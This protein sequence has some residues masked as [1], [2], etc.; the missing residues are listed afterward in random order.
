MNTISNW[1]K[2]NYFKT[3]LKSNIDFGNTSDKFVDLERLLEKNQESEST[4][5]HF[6]NPAVN[7]QQEVNKKDKYKDRERKRERRKV[8]NPEDVP[9]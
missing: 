2:N 9:T 3:Y 8:T 4:R 6:S 5:S 7:E 1:N